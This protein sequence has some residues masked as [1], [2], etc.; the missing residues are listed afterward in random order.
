MILAPAD[1]QPSSLRDLDHKQKSRAANQSL[2]GAQGEKEGMMR[3]Q[4]GHFRVSGSGRDCI[5]Q[6]QRET[7][8]PDVLWF[9]SGR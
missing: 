5:G 4:R 6:V 3:P 1:L 8:I 7:E 9:K 2:L